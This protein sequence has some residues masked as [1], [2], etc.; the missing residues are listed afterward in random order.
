MPALSTPT[1]HTTPGLPYLPLLD[2]LFSC[3]NIVENQAHDKLKSQNNLA[4]N[5]IN[6]M[7][8]I[9]SMINV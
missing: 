4:N 6:Y 9:K 8:Y 1:W 2:K 3:Q 7:I 5:S